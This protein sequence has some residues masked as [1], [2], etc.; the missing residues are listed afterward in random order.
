LVDYELRPLFRLSTPISLNPKPGTQFGE[1]TSYE[2]F[3]KTRREH[4]AHLLL[5]AEK[6]EEDE[7]EGDYHVYKQKQT[8]ETSSGRN[9]KASKSSSDN[10]RS[11]RRWDSDG[12]N[13]HG[14]QWKSVEQSILEMSGKVKGSDL[15]IRR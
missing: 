8:K 12:R 7:H 10:K 3:V 6:D 2:V 15:K 11:G 1:I 14:Y 4:F 5:L 13:A 9:L